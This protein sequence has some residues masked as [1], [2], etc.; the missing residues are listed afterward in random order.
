LFAHV[1]STKRGK[2]CNYFSDT[3]GSLVWPLCLINAGWIRLINHV[4]IPLVILCI[5]GFASP[6][7][8]STGWTQGQNPG[9]LFQNNIRSNW[10]VCFVGSISNL[11][12]KKSKKICKENCGVWKYGPLSYK[13]W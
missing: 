3:L 5:R 6:R 4:A 11:W 2:P 1:W 7:E 10:K 9:I 13:N 12:G 8:A